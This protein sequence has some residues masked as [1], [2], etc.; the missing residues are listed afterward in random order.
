MI[1]NGDTEINFKRELRKYET[2]KKPNEL[3]LSK[4]QVT[5]H[6]HTTCIDTYISQF[7]I[8]TGVGFAAYYIVQS[9]KS[10]SRRSYTELSLGV[11]MEIN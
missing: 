1:K 6:T 4:N 3:Y 7:R 2:P 8:F 10:N 5:K 9:K 11:N